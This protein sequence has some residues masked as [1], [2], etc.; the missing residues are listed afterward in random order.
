MVF[1]N[2]WWKELGKIPNFYF[3]LRKYLQSVYLSIFLLIRTFVI[4]EY[5]V[6]FILNDIKAKYSGVFYSTFNSRL[7]IR[8][9]WIETVR[10]ELMCSLFTLRERSFCLIICRRQSDVFVWNYQSLSKINHNIKKIIAWRT[11]TI[12]LF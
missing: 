11:S 5:W 8:S 4:V 7:R 12:I 3:S 2:T 9:R 10:L 6:L 1:Q